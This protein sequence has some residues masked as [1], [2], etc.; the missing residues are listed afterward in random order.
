MAKA[1]QLIYTVKDDK[2]KLATT[3]IKVPNGLTIANLIEFGQL[4]AAL[5]DEITSGQIVNVSIAFTVDISGAGLKVA[6]NVLADVEEKGTFQYLSSSGFRTT[7][8]VPCLP[9]LKVVAGSDA[10]DLADPD[11]AA[12]NAM[13][14]TGLALPVSAITVHPSDI[15]E[16]DI[17]SLDWARE[18]FRA[19]GKR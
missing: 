13:M 8:R 10:I 2:G 19:S 5:V 3:A 4:S 11:V 16:D 1:T 17:V 14:L 6:P 12:F 7:V 18:R 15:R 9:D